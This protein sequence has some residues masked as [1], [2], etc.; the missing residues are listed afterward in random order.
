MQIA[1]AITDYSVYTF[2]IFSSI[3]VVQGTNQVILN[4]YEG[5]FTL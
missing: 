3:I 5:F 2:K 1:K 4:I